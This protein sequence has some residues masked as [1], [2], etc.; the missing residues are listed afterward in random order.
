M[1]MTDTAGTAPPAGVLTAGQEPG[2]EPWV[3]EHLT[4]LRRD[5]AT[6][7]AD[8]TGDPVIARDP[9]ELR[10]FLAARPS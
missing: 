7:R 6:W 8:G 5:F 1:R 10:E 3:L 2:H 4:G 9:G